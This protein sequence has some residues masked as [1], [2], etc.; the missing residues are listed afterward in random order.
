MCRSLLLH[1]LFM[2]VMTAQISPNRHKWI[3]CFYEPLCS[4]VDPCYKSAH[5]TCFVTNSI[6]WPLGLAALQIT[7][8]S[9]LYV[10]LPIPHS[11]CV[12]SCIACMLPLNTSILTHVPPCNQLLSV[13]W[14][15][16]FLSSAHGS[17]AVW[18]MTSLHLICLF[19]ARDLFM[20]AFSY[21]ESL[22]WQL[23]MSLPCSHSPQCASSTLLMHIPWLGSIIL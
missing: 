8:H 16:L 10:F 4:Q 20:A 5:R 3:L 11:L 14:S 17:A 12:H 9:D 23:P 2:T 22:P 18:T 1:F 6:L 15:C 21:N 7:F 13:V 19:M